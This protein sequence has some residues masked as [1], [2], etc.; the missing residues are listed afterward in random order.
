MQMFNDNPNV[1]NVFDY[2]EQNNTAYIVMEFIEGLTLMQFLDKQ[3]DSRI[4]FPTAVSIIGAFADILERIH[5]TPYH[6]DNGNM[7]Q[8]MIHRD[9][10]PENIMF[11]SDRTIKLLDFGAARVSNP[12]EPPTGIILLMNKRLLLDNSIVNPPQKP[13]L[14][15]GKF[16]RDGDGILSTNVGTITGNFLIIPKTE[17]DGK[18]GVNGTISASQGNNYSESSITFYCPEIK[19]GSWNKILWGIAVVAC[20]VTFLFYDKLDTKEKELSYIKQEF[21]QNLNTLEKYREFAQ[22]YGYGSEHYYAEKAIVFLN[23]NSEAK[24]SIYCDLLFNDKSASCNFLNNDAAVSA[25]WE[26]YFNVNHK[27]TIIINSGN[28]TGYSTLKFTN[29]VNSDSFEVLIIVQ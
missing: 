9:I 2:F 28:S 20:G 4:D 22:D 29:E 24:L 5:H 12:G 11:S 10:S 14:Q 18:G 6:D 26:D 7:H 15:V 23:K 16:E 17:F 19:D 8:G 21:R 3:N 27:A 25:K 13:I 1:V